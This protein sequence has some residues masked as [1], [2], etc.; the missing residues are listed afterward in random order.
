MKNIHLYRNA[1]TNIFGKHYI[2]YDS[3]CVSKY[4]KIRRNLGGIMHSF[5][6]T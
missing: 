1:Y 5:P 6:H 3:L 2:E 4:N